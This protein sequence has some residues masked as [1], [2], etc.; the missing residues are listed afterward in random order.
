[1][2]DNIAKIEIDGVEMDPVIEY[3]FDKTGN[4]IIKYEL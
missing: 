3:Q 1:M 2:L 4:H